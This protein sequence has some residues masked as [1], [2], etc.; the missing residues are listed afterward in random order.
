MYLSILVDLAKPIRTTVRGAVTTLLSDDMD[1]TTDE[2]VAIRERWVKICL[3]KFMRIIEKTLAEST[4]G[5]LVGDSMTITDLKLYT[6]FKWFSGGI[7][8]GV[9]ST[10][11]DAF[12]YCHCFVE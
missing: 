3:P 11:F 7:L 10:A 1:F 9:P 8:I 2:K 4:S 6:T 12:P 5:W